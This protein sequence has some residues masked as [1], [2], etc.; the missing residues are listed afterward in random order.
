[1]AEEVLEQ[2]APAR[3]MNWDLDEA[4]YRDPRPF[5]DALKRSPA[6]ADARAGLAAHRREVGRREDEAAE[7][8][9]E[10]RRSESSSRGVRAMGKALTY[11]STETNILEN[12][13]KVYDTEKESIHMLMEK[14]KRASG[15]VIN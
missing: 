11:M 13:K 1:M 7:R 15:K 10:L 2:V 5:R 3:G 4:S 14:L 9:G 8:L 12:G 6:D